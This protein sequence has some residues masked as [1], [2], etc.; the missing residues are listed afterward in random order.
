[1]IIIYFSLIMFLIEI[2]YLSNLVTIFFIIY[3]IQ[4]NL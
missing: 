4:N 1:M 3:F 2:F